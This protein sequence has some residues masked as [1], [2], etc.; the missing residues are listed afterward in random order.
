M[1]NISDF[2]RY[3]VS[4]VGALVVSAVLIAA[5]TPVVPIA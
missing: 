1:T 2:S 5:A 4:F 3:A